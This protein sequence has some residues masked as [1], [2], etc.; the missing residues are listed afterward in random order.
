MWTTLQI[1]FGVL[2]ILLAF[3]G[4]R[5]SMPI[6]LYA[7]AA[8]FGLASIAIGWEA[9]VTR[10]IRLGSRR[11]GTRETYTGLAAV[12]HGVQ[13]NLIGLF[14]IGLSLSTYVNNGRE[15]VLQFVRRPG[16]PL[17]ILG[18]LCLMQAVI[19]LT[20]SHEQRQGPRW[21]VAMNL[22]AAR[23]LPGIV[24]IVIGVGA[25]WLGVFEIIAPEAF[26]AMGGG[27]LEVLYG[28][29]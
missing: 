14:L 7:G 21:M 26:D 4:D 16:V 20:G 1:I 29:R 27:Y 25:A 5:L 28:V 17:L 24:L 2:G 23:L 13:F 19:S 15:I 8:C 12:L 18:A 11:R 10:Q 3:G 22:V 6:L 9:I